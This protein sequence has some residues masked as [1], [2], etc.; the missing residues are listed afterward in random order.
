MEA[1]RPGGAV[2][3][4]CYKALSRMILRFRFKRLIAQAAAVSTSTRPFFFIGPVGESSVKMQ[5]NYR[6]TFGSE[7]PSTSVS[8]APPSC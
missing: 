2:Q 4:Y 8:P 5:R 1:C 7:T 3:P 6:L